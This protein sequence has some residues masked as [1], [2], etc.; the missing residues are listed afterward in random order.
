MRLVRYVVPAL[1]AGLLCALPVQGQQTLGTVAGKVVDGVTQQPLVG[2]KVRL[3]G[4][5]RETNS[6]SDGTFLLGDVPA[7]GYKVAATRIGFSPVVQD[8]TV[9]AGATANVQFTLQPSA[10]VLDPVVVTGYGTQRREAVTAS[11]ATVDPGTANV[12]VISNV[13]QLISGRA[14]GV[15]V[16]QN[17]G[18]PGAGAQIRIRGGTS[19]GA[20]NDPL[21]VI[22]GVPVT[23]TNIE[24]SGL[25]L[26]SSPSLPRSPL[27]LL[28]PNDVASITILKD[29][30]ATAIYGSRGANGVVLI[31]TKKGTA[32]AVGGTT[33][34]Y[35]SYFASASPAR[36]L[37]PLTGEEYR[38]FVQSQVA[39]H[40]TDPTKGLDS[41]FLSVLDTV[42]NVNTDWERAVTRSPFT[43]NHNLS[44]AGGSDVTRYRA[45]L[46]YMDQQG[47]GL[48]SGFTRIQGRLS[49]THQA[50][51]SR[52][53]LGLNVS[54]SQTSDDYLSAENGGGF[55]G[56]VFVN[57]V[58]FN[59]TLPVRD[60]TGKYY[61]LGT[62]A[63]SI[64]NPVALANQIDDFGTATRTLGNATAE[65]DLLPGLTGSVNVG[66]DQSEGIRQSY[67]PS[68]SPAG[69]GTQGRARQANR[70]LA[71]VTFQGQLSYRRVLADVH[72]LDVTGVYEFTENHFK[73]FSAE[74][75]GFVTDN[76][77]FNA[78]NSG[79]KPQP[80]G[81]SASDERWI[82][83]LSRVNYGYKEKYYL[84]GVVRY[85]GRSAFAEGHKWSLFPGL[86][87][88][89]HLS[90]EDF[91][92]NSPFSDLRLR[93]GWGT[94]GNPGVSA[95]SSLLKI[96]AT[97]GARYV[98]GTNTIVG[99]APV[100]N[101]NPDLKFERTSQV[102]AALDVGLLQN[103][104]SGTVEYY[105]KNTSDLLLEIDVPQPAAAKTRIQNVGKVRI[106]GFEL[107]LDAL[108]I[109]H[110]GMTLRAGIV[111]SAERNKVI[112][113]GDTASLINSGFASGEGQSG[114]VSQVV[115]AGLPLGTFWGPTYAGVDT[116]GVQR[117]RCTVVDPGCVSG[118][119]TN[120]SL[121]VIGPIGNA[122][123][124]FTLGVHSELSW[125]KLD[126]SVL[127]RAAFGQDVFNNT[128]LVYGTKSKVRQG[129]NFLAT[130]LDD[131]IA[132]GQPAIFSSHWVQ[133]ASYIRVQNI[134]VGYTFDLPRFA[135]LA[136]T[137]RV[138]ASGDNL[139]LL[140]GYDGLDP[141]VHAESGVASRG[142]D[143]LSYPRPRTFTAG[144]RLAF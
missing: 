17:S 96:E 108:A 39:L 34:E 57:V 19:I 52:L 99:F 134:T 133:D 21:Y 110:P 107:S 55:E 115:K 13:N 50:L 73:E 141:E 112:T 69:A 22:D 143:Y 41:T 4:I 117:F 80:P 114:Q 127:V 31:E 121:A 93:L 131:P 144:V 36:R 72:N 95:Y 142:I 11:I 58:S 140:T 18:E 119:T 27:N 78:L 48:G 118:L 24:P 1:V 94:V 43:S 77:S 70:N 123:P 86:S 63:Q 132:I 68:A 54:T 82:S 38:A 136:R 88:S 37:H 84:T 61:E 79:D 9:A 104:L 23:N 16:L 51:N 49:G 35:E 40:N 75:Q 33:I 109:A 32:G 10:A 44:F 90:Q 111:L 2:V 135:G 45:S 126:A 130:A 81:S 62:G 66:V 106:R 76:L 124:D 125:G 71:S 30:S 74:S 8:V 15:N 83:F 25:T 64:R 91:M 53:R 98:F 122:Y 138:Y 120:K 65:L 14:A 46:N 47:V 103:R 56:G 59:P 139:I 3:E 29:A 129:R 60:S 92:R 7:G 137:A 20:S 67:I 28:N 6:A 85:D 5:R 89:W 87:G 42:Y 101:P 12:G 97:S 128:G 100:S 116:L 26:G 105:V 113:I 102:N